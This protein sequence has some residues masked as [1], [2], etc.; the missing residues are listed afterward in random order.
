[1][2]AANTWEGQVGRSPQ[3]HSYCSLT[4]ARR[5]RR[6]CYNF[7]IYFEL[8]VLSCL[9]DSLTYITFKN[10]WHYIA[11]FLPSYY[12]LRKKPTWKIRDSTMII[13]VTVVIREVEKYMLCMENNGQHLVMSNENHQR[14]PKRPQLHQKAWGAGTC[15]GVLR[16]MNFESVISVRALNYFP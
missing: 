9:Y 2:S 15:F 12:S 13:E 16:C 4:F 10:H 1:M 3:I 14:D 7:Q 8:W 11:G 6:S 5:I